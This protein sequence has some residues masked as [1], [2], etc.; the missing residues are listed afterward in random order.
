MPEL[1]DPRPLQAERPRPAP[2]FRILVADDDLDMRAFLQLLL[3][4]EGMA[5][6]AV[7]DGHAA[8][9]R[10][11]A[12]PP[13]L[14]LLDVVMPG[15]SGFEVCRELKHDEATALIPIVLVT[16]LDDQDSRVRGIE[17]GADDFLSKP[18]HR[19]ELIARVKT[20]RRL[21]ETRR[22][23]EG[24][25]LAAEVERKEAIRK[26]FSRY[27]APRLAD[28]IID[29]L[30]ENGE[31]FEGRAQRIEVVALF[32]DLRGFTRLTERV[33]GGEVVAM[34]NEYFSVL[35][36]AAYRHDGTIFSMAGDSLLVGFNVPFVQRDAAVRAW[37]TAR[38]M[39]SRFA[40]IAAMW[41]DRTGFG[42]GVGIG[43]CTG[44]AIIGNVGSPHYMSYTIIGNPVNV[45]AR[46]MQI[47]AAD[48]VLLCGSMYERLKNLLPRGGVEGRGDV[49][50]R[51]RSEPIPVYSVKIGPGVD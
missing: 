31:L 7:G 42:T 16:T 46:L 4:R 48:E 47:A 50:L 18:I 35:T 39:V 45:A 17:A 36:D 23:L 41:R 15:P 29:N 13:D 44:E 38:E 43:I 37:R 1:A 51:G 14:I 20:L 5:V 28:H 19:E 33:E 24:R 8:L 30:G 34:L 40:P 10:V 25:R 2:G 12:S 32:A 6:E 21:H 11:R 9:M 3:G 49:T 22:E 27:V 26:T